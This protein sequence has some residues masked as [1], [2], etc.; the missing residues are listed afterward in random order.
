MKAATLI[1]IKFSESAAAYS[2]V[3]FSMEAENAQIQARK[4][5]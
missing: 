2:L 4:C 5:G 3:G 1:V